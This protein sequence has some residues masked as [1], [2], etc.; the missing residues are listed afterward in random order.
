MIRTFFKELLQF[1]KLQVNP[2]QIIGSG[3]CMMIIL[4]T[5]YFLHNMTIASF[6]SLG[7]F[8]FLYYQNLPLKNLLT[9]LSVI[10]G[11]IFLS[12]LLGTLSTHASWTAPLAVAASAFSGRVFFRLYAITKPGAFFGV[13]VA[14]MATNIHI[15]L[16]NLPAASAFFM[17][18]VGLSLLV[19]IGV[20]FTEKNLPLI[21][22]TI[23]FKQRL[24]DDPAV[25][26]DGIFYAGTLFLAVYLSQGLQLQNPY[27]LVVSCAAILQGDN[28]R[29]MM[30]RNA[31]R[32]FGT[33][34]G[35]GISAIL[36]SLPLTVVQT[37]LLITLLYVI[38]EYSIRANYALANFFTTPM[39]L[40]LS[41]LI[42][43]QYVASL[44]QFRFIGIVLGSLLGVLAAWIMTTG[45]NFYNQ[46]FQLHENLDRET[47]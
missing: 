47:D 10:G 6:G 24:A 15:P 21:L 41:T 2:M 44:L 8:V 39:A 42:K 33:T 34:I 31:Q 20:H 40:P 7:V 46:A 26:L 4:F 25:I 30:Q 13:M 5:G 12:Y 27:W 32:I 3:L 1:R 29:A 45:L 35:I 36:L 14:A 23:P 16:K 17:L 11:Y 18:G 43:Q 28:L 9:R 22:P 37:L 38:V 19:A